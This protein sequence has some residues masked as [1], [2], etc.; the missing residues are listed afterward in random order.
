MPLAAVDCPRNVQ[1]YNSKI[2]KLKLMVDIRQK[3]IEDMISIRDKFPCSFL[4]DQIEGF[5]SKFLIFC[6]QKSSFSI[7]I[8]SCK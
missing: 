5:V 2:D 3:V 6:F 8:I 4:S 7:K 1:K